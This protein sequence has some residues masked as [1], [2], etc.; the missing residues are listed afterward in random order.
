MAMSVISLILPILK[1]YGRVTLFPTLGFSATV[2]RTSFPSTSEFFA[3]ECSK[4]KCVSMLPRTNL[5]FLKGAFIAAP[6]RT[7]EEQSLRPS[8][9]TAGTG[10]ADVPLAE[11]SGFQYR[12]HCIE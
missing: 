2:N 6:L 7:P 8:H 1:W 9:G 4:L 3:R 5:S 12:R 10:G 11:R